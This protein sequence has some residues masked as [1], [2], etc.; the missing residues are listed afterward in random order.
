MK[1]NY[2]GISIFILDNYDKVSKKAAQLVSAQI[3]LKENSVLGLATGSTPEGMYKELIQMYKDHILDFSSVTTFNLDEYY[4]IDE[5]NPKSY[6]YYMDNNLFN[7]ININRDNINIPSGKIDKDKIEAF[8]NYYD[9]SI[10]NAGKI[11]L[12]VLGIGTN[13]HIGFNEPD[14]HFE[15]GTHLVDLDPKTIE[16][17]SR[18]FNS[19]K[20]VPTQAISIGIRNIMQSKKVMLM[21]SGASKAEVIEKTIFGEVTPQLPASILQVHNDVT[22]ILDKEAG[23]LIIDK[24]KNK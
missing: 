10:F 6:H 9:A 14:I 8:C 19:A 16:A 3:T 5:S 17:N 1:F 18:F 13:G 2:R 11:D 23:S 4:N 7:S 20:E 12:Q 15:A 22:I 24:L 21:A